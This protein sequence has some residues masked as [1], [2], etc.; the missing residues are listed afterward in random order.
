MSRNPTSRR[1]GE[2][3][4]MSAE[5]KKPAPGPYGLTPSATPSGNGAFNVYVV[6]VTGRKIA[7]IWG[8]P[9]EREATADLFIAASQ[10]PGAEREDAEG[11]DQTYKH[12]LVTQYW[13]THY[14]AA[15]CALCDNAGIVYPVRA[16][17]TSMPAQ[18]CICPNGQKMRWMTRKAAP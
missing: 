18:W 3:Q 10:V 15:R 11:N 5:Q 8:K 6:D 1:I 2:H 9:E 14:C 17:G 16:G 4:A 12:E 13:L 7:A